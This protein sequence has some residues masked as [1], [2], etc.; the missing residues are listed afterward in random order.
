MECE[1]VHEEL[2]GKALP[3]A[4]FH[5]IIGIIQIDVNI[6]KALVCNHQTWDPIQICYKNVLMSVQ[7]RL[8]KLI[9]NRV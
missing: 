4:A 9:L 8:L 1:G 6:E 3:I 2:Q 5:P 7:I